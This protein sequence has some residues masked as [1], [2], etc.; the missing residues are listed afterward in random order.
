MWNDEEK[1]HFLEHGYLHARGVLDPAL[2]E[3]VQTEF[4]DIWKATPGRCNQHVLLKHRTFIDLI[5]H[6]PILDRNAAIF[7]YQTQLLQY[8]FLRQPPNSMFPQRQWHRDLVFPGDYPLSCNSIVYLDDMTDETGPT[9]VVPGSH[10]GRDMPPKDQRE[11]PLPGEVPVYA[12]AGD[13]VFINSAIWHSGSHNDSQGLR[14]GIY[15]YYGHWW[16]KRYEHATTLPPACLVDASPQ[17]LCLLGLMMP[18][19]R[20]RAQPPEE[21]R[22]EETDQSQ[23][24]L[25]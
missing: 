5:E 24:Y 7:G 4:E 17:R 19:E 13:C 14:R 10:R 3:K 16:M 12:N 23:P 1:D 22:E 15:M 18:G 6:K 8:D 11:Q 25:T 20:L 21:T 9:Y 2:L